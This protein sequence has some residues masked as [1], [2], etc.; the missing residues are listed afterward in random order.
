MNP[1]FIGEI[2]WDKVNFKK[3]IQL[4]SERMYQQFLKGVNVGDKVTISFSFKRPSRTKTQLNYYFVLVGILSDHLGY[5]KKEMHDWLMRLKW[6]TKEIKVGNKVET[7]RE[8]VSDVAEFPLE[9]MGEQIEFTLE[10]CKECG[11]NIPTPAELGY[12]SPLTLKI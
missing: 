4:V 11:L 3:R 8:S 10:V 7:V 12:Y 9:K 2:V 1:I 5:T 6:G